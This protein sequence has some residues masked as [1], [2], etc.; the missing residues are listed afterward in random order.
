[1]GAGRPAKYKTAEEM[2]VKIDEY[3]NSC[4]EDAYIVKD[5]KVIMLK[6]A[7]GNPIKRQFKPFTV[8]GLANALEMDRKALITYAEEEE[9]SNTIKKAKNRC[10]QYAE[11]RL[12]DRDGNRGAIFSLSNNFKS[13]NDKQQIEMTKEPTL[14]INI[15]NNDSLK[16]AFYEKEEQE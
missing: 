3:F 7:K 12:F 10:E 13:W 15:N 5:G 16:E 9:F 14:N 1:M 11:E 6:D 8:T 4:F 2:Q